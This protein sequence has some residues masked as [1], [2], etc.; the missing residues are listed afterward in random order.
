M[1][2]C[3]LNSSTRICENIIVLNSLS[4][5]VAYKPGIELAPRHDGAIGWTLGIDNEWIVPPE[6]RWPNSQKIRNIRNFRLKQSD[7]YAYPDFPLTPEKKQEW[8]TY[9]QLLRDVT[10]QPT[11]PDSVIWP[12]KPE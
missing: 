7:K 11:F 9:R 5:F 10:S 3:I 8:L 1:N 4:E 12:T 6:N 2:A